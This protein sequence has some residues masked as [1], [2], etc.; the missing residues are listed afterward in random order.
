MRAIV[1]TFA[2]DVSHIIIFLSCEIN[3]NILT[4]TRNLALSHMVV[5][6]IINER[7]PVLFYVDE[8]AV[9]NIM[10]ELFDFSKVG[11]NGPTAETMLCFTGKTIP[12]GHMI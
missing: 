3:M 4:H 11:G 6:Q 7:T 9:R 10:Q 2:A 12:I 1:F 5:K 8:G